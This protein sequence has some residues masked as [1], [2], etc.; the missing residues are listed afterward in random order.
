M[1]RPRSIRRAWVVVAV[2]AAV[3][4]GGGIAYASIPGSDGRISG[5]Y[6]PLNGKLR[7]IDS[8]A[9]QT[10]KRNEQPVSWAQS[11]RLVCPAGTTLSTGVCI[12]DAARAAADHGDA[13]DA[14]AA[15]GRRLPS[16]GELTTFAQRPG[17]QLAAG[18]EW[19]D[20]LGDIT[21]ASTFAYFVIADPGNGVKTAFDD[22]A[23]RCVAG[24]GIG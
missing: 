16:A 17:V 12:E 22:T 23:F 21:Y 2:A 1:D 4:L 10:C 6:E 3:V 19:T 8:E 13:G 9:G 5:C 18:G 11:A 24:A 7:L 15:V 20:D 14:C